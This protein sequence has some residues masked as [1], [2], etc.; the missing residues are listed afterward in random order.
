MAWS[1]MF[2]ISYQ[3]SVISYQSSVISHQLSASEGN[4]QEAPKKNLA[5]L[6]PKNK[7]RN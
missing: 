4:R 2:L 5:I 1:A 3:L 6:L 7:V